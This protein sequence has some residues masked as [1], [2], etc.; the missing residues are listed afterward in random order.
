MDIP[1]EE[2]LRQDFLAE[3]RE[4]LEALEE[5][6]LALENET[7]EAF[8]GRVDKVFRSLHTLKGSSGCLNFRNLMNLSHS[9]ETLFDGVRKGALTLDGGA[10]DLLL[11]GVDLLRRM[12]GNIEE[13][14]TIDISSL[15][16]SL[17]ELSGSIDPQ[18]GGAAKTPLKTASG[19]LSPMPQAPEPPELSLDGKTLT[20]WQNDYDSAFGEARGFLE[21]I[22]GIRREL[23]KSARAIP[24]LCRNPQPE[25][26][27]NAGVLLEG[28][29]DAVRFFGQQKLSTRLER[30]RELFRNLAARVE[31][32]EA[33][34]ESHLIR[35]HEVLALHA[36]NL[37]DGETVD[38]AELDSLL[39]FFQKRCSKPETSE[40]IRIHRDDFAAEAKSHLRFIERSF[41][42]WRDKHGP[43]STELLEDIFRRV[44]SIKGTA[45]TLGL[46]PIQGLSHALETYLDLLRT[47]EVQFNPQ[48]WKFLFA[49]FDALGAML[50]DL[51]HCSELDLSSLKRKFEALIE[52]H[53]V[54]PDDLPLSASR[55]RPLESPSKIPSPDH[56]RWQTFISRVQERFQDL[57]FGLQVL[58][59]TGKDLDPTALGVLLPDLDRIANEAIESGF[60]D[61]WK[62]L[63][64]FGQGLDRMLPKALKTGPMIEDGDVP[65]NSAIPDSKDFRH[66][67]HELSVIFSTGTPPDNL[68]VVNDRIHRWAWGELKTVPERTRAPLAS[69]PL[70]VTHKPVPER[71]PS[72]EAPHSRGHSFVPLPEKSLS[73]AESRTNDSGGG[74]TIRL[75]VELLDRLMRLAGELVLIRN[76]QLFTFEKSDPASRKIIQRLDLLTTELQE[77]IMTTR[78]QPVGN[79]MNKIPRLVRDLGRKLGKKVELT[80]GGLEV[81]VDK[82]ILEALMDPMLH[83]VRNC[84]DHGI[85]SPGERVVV[86]KKETGRINIQALHEGGQITISVSD[87]G[88]GIDPGKIRKKAEELRLRS[89]ADLN[90]MTDKE[91]LNLILLPGFS[92]AEKVSEVSGR[93][94][95]MDVV[96]SNIEKLGGAL[97]FNTR[98]GMGTELT[99]RLPLTLAIV[100]CLIVQNGG[101]RF[102]IPQFNV[103]ELVSLDVSRNRQQVEYSRDMEVFRLRGR[104]LP[105]VR[106]G[107]ILARPQ[108]FTEEVR[109]E[110]TEK[111]RRPGEPSS[112][113]DSGP[114][115]F[116]V[117]KVG[118]L[119]FGLMVDKVLGNE[120][121]VVRPMHPAVKSCAI[122]SGATI[123]GDG[124]VA[125]ILDAEG[126]ARHYGLSIEPRRDSETTEAKIR[127][128]KERQGFLLFRVG[129]EETFALPLPFIR[130]IEKVGRERRI[131]RV[132]EKDFINLQGESFFILYLDR[133]LPISPRNPEDERFLLVPHGSGHQFGLMVSK[134]EDV[135]YSDF[136]FSS[137]N[138]PMDGLFG[139]AVYGDRTLMFPDLFRLIDMAMPDWRSGG[140]RTRRANSGKRALVVDDTA[141]FSHLVRS[142]LE[143]IGVQAVVCNSAPEALRQVAFETFDLIVSDLEMPVMDG[144]DFARAVR[145]IDHLEKVPMLALTGSEDPQVRQMALEAGFDRFETKTNRGAFLT[146]VGDFFSRDGFEKK[147]GIR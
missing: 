129:P 43:L 127:S 113:Q 45:G 2:N 107:E 90:K 33:K 71:P 99:I 60:P 3:A 91:V 48:G 143:S 47:N 36:T 83:I 78:M 58:F 64:T 110:I 146:A 79:V 9:M 40:I 13:S 94:V 133:I 87:D 92:T 122:Y 65:K 39:T 121:I 16:G 73:G 57:V 76:Q 67:L 116:I 145:A 25:H 28:F 10:T 21:K 119:L 44:H 68:E 147:G 54:K 82:T 70:P 144:F 118:T 42:S 140:E 20:E 75:R 29:L 97:D 17:G 139:Q 124:K 63:R 102:A 14:D 77:T 135:V 136:S 141:F 126:L 24:E 34:E 114:L 123:M 101:H 80:L 41:E 35:L 111:F 37:D 130:R 4:H 5:N 89:V 6:I 18:E 93:G 66:A 96:K 22:D 38:F 137:E 11:Q 32:F 8:R 125:L 59:E 104:L 53:R 61:L 7:G 131:D 62:L 115:F 23:E 46:E 84:C 15:I 1:L 27:S 50:D 132:G 120:E 56:G 69:N 138:L 112:R 100:P 88:R 86:G 109:M 105:L 103:Q 108:P 31:P 134:L 55:E 52:G 72:G 98:V 128:N 117:L 30:S 19:P 12:I 106:L 81:E 74:E 26:W 95:G 51:D 142:F 85:E 49:N